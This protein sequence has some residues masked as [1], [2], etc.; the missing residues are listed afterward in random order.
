MK[1]VGDWAKS[2]RR[3]TASPAVK[4]SEPS[5]KAISFNFSRFLNVWFNLRAAAGGRGLP[6][7]GGV[8]RRVIN[9]SAPSCQDFPVIVRC[10]SSVIT[11]KMF[12][13]NVLEGKMLLNKITEKE[14][15]VWFHADFISLNKNEQ[16]F[17]F[18]EGNVGFQTTEGKKI[19]VTQSV[20]LTCQ[21]PLGKTKEPPKDAT[22]W[23][24]TRPEWTIA[25]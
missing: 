2:R 19:Y 13:I 1:S 4:A 3:F 21:P 20:V 10:W 25:F 23:T 7:P 15:I 22:D 8:R 9:Q 16:Y 24:S 5:F 12:D 11:L 17:I 18:L 14:T 6:C